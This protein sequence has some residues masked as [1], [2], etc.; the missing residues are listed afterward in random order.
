MTTSEFNTSVD[1][2]SDGIYRFILKQ[3]RDEERA[4][5]IVQDTWEKLWIN[6]EQVEAEKVKSWLFTTAYHRMI[7]VIRVQKRTSYVEETPD[8][9]SADHQP[10]VDLKRW[11]NQALN[12][13]PEIQKT[14]VLLRDYEG[15]SYDEIGEICQ[16]NESQVKVYIY[17][18]R[19]AMQKYLVSV[20][21]VI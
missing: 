20:E 14:V 16:L 17:R 12:T 4:R 9:H 19:L 7:D 21:A 5:D 6:R 10:S 2:Y 18:A 1:Q 8:Y 13:L 11:I 15:Y 3:L